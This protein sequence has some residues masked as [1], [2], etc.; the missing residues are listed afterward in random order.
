MM[1]ADQKTLAEFRGTAVCAGTGLMNKRFN[2][3]AEVSVRV[4][5]DRTRCEDV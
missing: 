3:R 2:K 5:C 1:Q 4:E